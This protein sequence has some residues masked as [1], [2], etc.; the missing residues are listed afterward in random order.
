MPWGS[1]RGWGGGAVGDDGATDRR[2][3]PGRGGGPC[4]RPAPRHHLGTGGPGGRPR[5]RWSVGHPEYGVILPVLAPE[6]R[7][8]DPAAHRPT[9]RLG[10]SPRSGRRPRAGSLGVAVSMAAVAV[11]VA[12]APYG[13]RPR[14]VPGTSATA[15]VRMTRP[16]V[17]TCLALASR[18]PAVFSW[19]CR[20][21]GRSRESV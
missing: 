5:I 15:T 7:R 4:R 17:S 9:C 20:R 1:D 21:R 6:R 18:S 16:R 10:T 8:R 19:V 11:A 14:P 13:H 12:V 3:K 2:E